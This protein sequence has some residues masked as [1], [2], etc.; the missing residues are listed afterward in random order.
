M[1]LAVLAAVAM[2]VGSA[3]AAV[4]GWSVV[5]SPSTSAEDQNSLRGV[6]CA[7]AHDCWAVG[8]VETRTSGYVDEPL[9]E[10][11]AGGGWQIVSS[12][13][14][15]GDDAV[16]YAVA[17]VSSSEC[18]AAGYYRN[19]TGVLQTLIERYT[20]V[21]WVLVDSPSS[22]A[23]QTNVLSSVACSSSADCWAV[24]YQNTGTGTTPAR[25]LIEHY[26]GAAWT[27]VPSRDT[28]A[29]DLL[30]GITCGSDGAC[31]AV[32][33]SYSSDGYKDTVIEEY[34]GGSWTLVSSPGPTDG[35]DP[36]L[37]S[38]A[39][40]DSDHCWAVGSYSS[41]PY[42]D[43]SQP[44]IEQFL[45]GVWALASNTATGGYDDQLLSVTCVTP[46]DC[47]AAGSTYPSIRE[48]LLEHYGGS[49]WSVAKPASGTPQQFSDLAAV[50]CVAASDCWAVGDT[51]INGS[52]DQTLIEHRG[53]DTTTTSVS[54]APDIVPMNAQTTCTAT[55]ADNLVP[56]ST[57]SGAVRW[58]G[59]Q[60]SFA[61]SSCTLS[62]G[63][64]SVTFTPA[65]GSPSQQTIQASYR[66][67]GSHV[68]SS[69]TVILAVTL[70]ST[71]TALVCSPN[72]DAASSPT[73][74]TVNVADTDSGAAVVPSGTVTFKGGAG[75]AAFSARS[76]T[77][78]EGSCSVTYTPPLGSQSSHT[79][80]AAYTG[81]AGHSPS[82]GRYTLEVT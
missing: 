41:Y 69:G 24:G 77:L 58:S 32:G 14:V 67:D 27:I 8:Y 13:T 71:S 52:T 75:Y 16:L 20:G 30:R 26:D 53:R 3:L 12:P 19:S 44:F 25:T 56:A 40:A 1:A 73:T 2:P 34:A 17:C 80:T 57:P 39:C 60:G 23:S 62:G 37:D 54:C 65:L 46:T 45:D 82:K 15:S 22:S 63:A 42:G 10:H 21:A 48:P 74:C 61:T 31:W 11:D 4:G 5:S 38:V 72:P 7:G 70:R 33:L 64:C 36:E 47:W 79:L 76:C 59:G 49:S 28:N 78:S 9:I 66:P 55:V 43:A 29:Q 18:W 68:A 35:Q 81:D 50:T 51:E 6:A